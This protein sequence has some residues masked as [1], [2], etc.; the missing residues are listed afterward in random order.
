MTKDMFL[1]K[2]T[3]LFERV[4]VNSENKRRR[5]LRRCIQT[6]EKLRLVILFTI[7]ILRNTMNYI[8]VSSTASQSGHQR[9]DFRGPTYIDYFSANNQVTL[10]HAQ[11]MRCAVLSPWPSP[12]QMNFPQ[13]MPPRHGGSTKQKRGSEKTKTKTKTKAKTR[14]D[15][16]DGSTCIRQARPRSLT[17][18]IIPRCQ[19]SYNYTTPLPPLAVLEF[20]KEHGYNVVGTNTIGDTCLW[21]LH[22]QT[23]TKNQ[24]T[25]T[26]AAI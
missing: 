9:V 3:S 19:F 2:T 25:Q 16:K 10:L 23:G 18:S 20:L 21:T 13:Q 14:I 1:R 7:K 22:K 15:A 4:I 5:C 12:Q 17:P 8:L 6:V 26:D 24:S 11:L